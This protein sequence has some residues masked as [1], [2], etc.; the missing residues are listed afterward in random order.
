MR[1]LLVLLTITLP[2]L[3][4]DSWISRGGYRNPING[5]WCCGDHDCVVLPPEAV[6]QVAGGYRLDGVGVLG[7]GTGAV[8][9]PVSEFVPQAEVQASRDGQYWRCHR[10]DRS[11]RCFFAPPP[12]M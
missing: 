4:H 2:A 12:S 1:V 8:D 6:R 5:E 11:R 9:V 7:S 3:A 10:P